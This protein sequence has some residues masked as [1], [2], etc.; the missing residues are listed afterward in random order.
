ML[1]PEPVN[2]LGPVQ[3][4]VN[5]PVPLLTL[6]VK[7]ADA[8]AQTSWLGG[9]IEQVGLG[10]TIKVAVQVLVQPKTSAT[11]AMYVPALAAWALLMVIVAPVA[12]NPLGPVQVKVKGAVPV[13]VAVK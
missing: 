7:V 13:A 11:V 2:P 3:A 4:I 5:G 9:A 12:V 6:T 10:F 8:P 1:V